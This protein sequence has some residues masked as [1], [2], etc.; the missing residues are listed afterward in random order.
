[1]ELSE[2]VEKFHD[3]RGQGFVA[4]HRRGPTGVGK[5]LED[6]LHLPENNIASPD[7]GLIELKAHRSN[8][9]SLITLFTFNRKVW[10]MK[11][12]DAIRQYGSLDPKG[13]LGMYYTMLLK[14]NSAGLFLY[15]EKEHVSVR[16]ISG[17][18]IAVWSLESLV[19]QFV[20]KIP[21]LI[22][23]SAYAEMRGDI[24]YFHY[25]RARLMKN[26]SPAL[27]ADQFREET[28]F[29]DLRLHDAETKAR[30]HGTG[31]RIAD[32]NLPSLF[33]EVIDL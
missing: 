11:P 13:R 21:A 33:R 28:I 18:V 29:L 1:M 4:S 12:L 6:L 7:L 8:S 14:P 17:N 27:L 15:V 24:E 9:T 20:R 2:F 22:V 23:V 3:L 31:F 5:T 19:Q 25:F 26:P 32:K 30:N 16:H 10:Q